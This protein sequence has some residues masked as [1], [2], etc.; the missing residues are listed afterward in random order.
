MTLSSGWSKT[1][2]ALLP[3][4]VLLPSAGDAAASLGQARAP[5][6]A[7]AGASLMPDARRLAVTPTAG[8]SLYTRIETPLESGTVVYEYARPDGLVFAVAWRGPVL[9]DLSTL[10][11]RYFNTFKFEIEQ[12]RLSGKRGSPV[13]IERVDLI[14]RSNGRMRN[15]FGHAYV[16]GLVPVGVNIQDVLP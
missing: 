13:N 14:V 12:A 1:L 16:P 15:F 2:R 9:P 5:L 11:G 8:V 4:L 6:P 10:L 3:A 7:T